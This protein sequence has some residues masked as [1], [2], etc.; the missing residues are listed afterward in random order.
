MMSLWASAPLQAKRSLHSRRLRNQSTR[1]VPQTQRVAHRIA[2]HLEQRQRLGESCPGKLHD[3]QQLPRRLKERVVLEE[4]PQQ[5]L[6][7][8]E[9]ALLRH[10]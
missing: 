10:H 9:L 5:R 6:R 4:L 2:R 7:V 8:A 1:N 3:H